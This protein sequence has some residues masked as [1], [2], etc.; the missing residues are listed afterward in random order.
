MKKRLA[1]GIL[2]VFLTGSCFSGS[3]GDVK[4]VFSDMEKALKGKDEALFKKQWHPEGFEKNLVGG[5]GLSGAEIYQE[6]SAEGWYLK[7]DLSKTT[8]TGKASIVFCDV[9]SFEKN[10]SLDQVYVL[11]ANKEEKPLVV[12]GGEDLNEVKALAERFAKNG[13]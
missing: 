5:S 12:G 2:L 8:N 3:T 13:R 6:G 4:T 11:V 7:P 10:K 1:I 9:W